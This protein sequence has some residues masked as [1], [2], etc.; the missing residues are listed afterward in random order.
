MSAPATPYLV[1]ESVTVRRGTRLILDDVSLG[2]HVGDRIGIVGRNGGGKTTLLRTLAGLVVPDDGRVL[3]TGGTTVGLVSQTDD[4]P[5][6]TVRDALVGDAADHE[7]ASDPAVRD[8]M[9]GLLGDV[10]ASFYRD[11]LQTPIAAMSGGELR[12]LALSAALI[13]RPDVL[14]LDEPTN[15]L[16]LES[17]AWLAAHLSQWPV[18][19]RALVVVTHDRWLL[20]RV[21][22]RTW[23]VVGGSVDAYEGGYAA[24]VLAKAERQRREAASAAKRR[25]LLRKELAWLQ[26]GAPARTSKPRFRVDAAETLIADEPPPRD[27][28]ALHRVASARLGKTVIDLEDVT[29]APAEDVDPV[30]RGQEF[31]LGPGERIGLLGPNGA[32][33]TTLLRLLLGGPG[34]PPVEGFVRRGKT[35]V[36]AVLGQQLSDVDADDRVLPWLRRGGDHMVVTTG[37]DLT[38]SQLLEMFGFTGDAP[39]KLL[40]DLSGG[41]RRRLQL[42][43]ILLDGPNLLMLDEPT[44]DLDIETLTVLEDLLDTWPGC[45]VVVSHDRYFLERVTDDIHAM[46]GDGTLRHLPRG[47]DEYLALRSDTVPAAPRPTD[48]ASASDGPTAEDLRQARKAMT[49]VERQLEKL[50]AE[51]TRLHE[52][53]AD[54]ATDPDRLIPLGQELA[55]LEERERDLEAEWLTAA[56]RTEG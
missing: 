25:N 12:R 32:G 24:Y 45:L 21:T 15:H 19:R 34:V 16:D 17:V 44:N 18:G 52:A 3:R 31:R 9:A 30:L 36:P 39:H 28:L 42:L 35:V 27:S 55:A 5:G 49:R 4:L 8:V 43:R 26:R 22:D 1:A 38:A 51:R 29:V 23:E 37:D 6:T 7:W 47:V 54:A 14:M 53:L 41:E 50:A 10:D 2:V 40:G 11:G 13:R 20:D 48:T 33:K 46:P 56:E